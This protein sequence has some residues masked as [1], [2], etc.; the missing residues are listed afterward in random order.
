[1]PIVRCSLR[2]VIQETARWRNTRFAGT[3]FGS[4]WTPG[5]LFPADVYLCAVLAWVDQAR[6]AQ[7]GP[8]EPA[9]LNRLTLRLLWQLGGVRFVA[10]AGGE[11]GA[12]KPDRG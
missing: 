6:H 7:R 10:A 11:Q 9:L 12:H 5:S 3:F 1:M 2:P 4:S 8:N